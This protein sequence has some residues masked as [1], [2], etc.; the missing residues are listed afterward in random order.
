MWEAGGRGSVGAGHRQEG[1]W[2][3]TGRGLLGQGPP[4]GAHTCWGWAAALSGDHPGLTSS[5]SSSAPTTHPSI[6]P[7]IKRP[8]FQNH[9]YDREFK[10]CL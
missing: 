1:S 8:L 9:H 3:G 6:S 2:G 10:L 5:G 4:S 7:A